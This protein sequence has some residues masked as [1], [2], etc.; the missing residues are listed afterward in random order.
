MINL[1]MHNILSIN[2]KPIQPST[3]GAS[4]T[5]LTN[6]RGAPSLPTGMSLVFLIEATCVEATFTPNLRSYLAAMI[7]I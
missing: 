1:A 3:D 7:L 4:V 6:S 5:Q 2:T